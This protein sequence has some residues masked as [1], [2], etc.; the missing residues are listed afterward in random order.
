MPWVL[1]V[2]ANPCLSPDAG[3]AAALG[4]AGIGYEAAVARLVDD[5]LACA[6]RA[7]R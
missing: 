5:A 3:F 6:G 1:E 2:N 7:E 4:E